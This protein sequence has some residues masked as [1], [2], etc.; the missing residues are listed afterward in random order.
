MRLSLSWLSDH[1]DIDVS[2]EELAHKLDMTGTKVEAIHRPGAGIEG[3][4]VAEVLEIEAH[5]NADNLLI[6]EVSTGNDDQQRVVC[7]AK[8]LS[9]GDRVPLAQVGA[10]LPE[11]TITERKIRGEVSRGMLCSSAE[12]GVAQDHS[13][14]LL[15]QPG[16]PLGEDVVEL[17]GLRDVILELEL[18][19]NRPDC[20]SVI[21]MAREI[22]AI[23]GLELRVPPAEVVAQSVEADI[24]IDIEDPEGSPRYLARLMTGVEVGPSPSWMAARLIAAGFRP[25][26]NVVDVTNY[27]LLETGQ[28]LHAFDADKVSN[29]QIVVRRAAPG[30]SLITLDGVTRE[31]HPRDL[32]IADP[33][34]ALAI[35]GVMGGLDSEVSDGTSEVV[36]EAAIFDK[37]SVAFTSRRHGLRSEASARFERGVDPEGTAYAA[38]RAAGLMS[39][40]ASARVAEREWD[41]YP[42]P[43]RRPSITLDPA[44][45]EKLLGLSIPPSTQADHLRALG[46]DVEERAGILEASVPSFRPDLQLEADLIEEV[47]RLEGFDR[48]P[49]TVPTGPAGGLD[50]MQKLERSIRRVLVVLG[51]TEAWTSSFMSPADLDALELDDE[52]PAHRLVTMSNPML[53]DEPAIRSTLLPGLLRSAARNFS[54]RAPGVALFEVGRVYAPARELAEEQLA[55][56]AVFAGERLP[57]SWTGGADLWGFPAVKGILEAAM[58]DVGAGPLSFAP[59]GAPP[60]HPTRAAHVSLGSTPLGVLGQLRPDIAEHWGLPEETIVTELAMAPILVASAQT[61]KA[62]ELPRFPSMLL[63]LAVVL[64]EGIAASAVQD[65]VEKAGRPEVAAVRLFDVY[66]GPQV[67]NGQKSLAFALELRDAARTLTDEDAT[68]VTQRILLALRERTGAELRT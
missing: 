63:D 54:H 55:L 59:I 47:A 53:E 52:H 16:A 1:V 58:V 19:P 34:Q 27:V 49:A 10:R 3:V 62:I 32:V 57:Q 42:S 17:L 25:I 37:A 56:S 30:E 24:K 38:R 23:F 33:G 50:P 20:M 39:E 45:T 11:M 36:L 21:G 8:N 29:H 15:L 31:L 7:G 2:P 22:A 14:I 5:P 48:L 28:P 13:G 60:F 12:L 43:S 64:D 18:T 35:A 41:V 65:V 51:A 61:H 4:T 6:V 68:R 9:V 67:L 46:I 66:R 44:R 40:V 26:S